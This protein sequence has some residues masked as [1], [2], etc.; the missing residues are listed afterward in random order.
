MQSLI[1]QIPAGKSIYV[2]LVPPAFTS[3]TPLSS[4]RNQ[5]N[6]EYNSVITTKLSN[7]EPEHPD[8]FYFFLEQANRFSLFYDTLHP[9]ALGQLIMAYLWRNAIAGGTDL[10][11]FL[12]NL[13]PS[14]GTPF[15]KQNLLEIG[16]K[17]YVDASFTLTGIPS[18]LIN[19]RWIMTA[20]NDKGDTSSEYLSFEVERNV[21]VYVAYDSDATEI[22]DWLS[23]SNGFTLTSSQLATSDPAV[24]TLDLYSR[25]YTAGTISLEKP[26]WWRNRCRQLY[27]DCGRKLKHNR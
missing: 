13:S 15:L 10:P 14:T 8:F 12:E 24:P 16:D 1:N 20:N 19:G 6:Q 23:S 26:C 27:C 21:T 17:Y 3:P 4:T 9:N 7:I 11:F 5:L 25:T 22:P 18:E 2:A